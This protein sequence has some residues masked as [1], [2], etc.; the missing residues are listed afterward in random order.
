[1]VLTLSKSLIAPLEL[2]ESQ[3]QRFHARRVSLDKMVSLREK[4]Y[5]TNIYGLLEESGIPMGAIH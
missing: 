5:D 2:V 1:M 3:I 4:H